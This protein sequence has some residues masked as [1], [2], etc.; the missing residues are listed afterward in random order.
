MIPVEL[1]NGCLCCGSRRIAF[2]PVL[3]K[4]LVDEWRLAPYEVEYID[5][6]Q[7]L[8]CEY[9][10]S[11][12][13]CMALALSLMR[14]YSFKGLFSDWVAQ[15]EVQR[16]DVLEINEAGL[17]TQ[18]LSRLPHHI[19]KTYPEMDMTRLPYPDNCFDLVIHS[20]SLEHVRHPIRGL[21]EC[22]RVLKP[23]GFCAFTVPIIMDRL[24]ISRTGMPPSY[25][26]ASEITASDYVVHSEYGSDAWRQVIQ[27]GFG[28][29]RIISL[30]F[31]AAQALVGVP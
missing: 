31:P 12:L 19:L 18:F 6:Q 17:L 11:K 7:G 13:R 8:H 27:A 5:C 23:Q 2:Q 14:C 20:D 3:W 26:G 9:C 16:L 30:G 29:C 4:E 1:E 21:S 24:T 15:S 28:E 25:H 22:R 10:G